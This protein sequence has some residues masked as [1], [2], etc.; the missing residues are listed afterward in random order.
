MSLSVS[1]LSVGYDAHNVLK[2]LN[3]SPLEKGSF[4]ALLGANAAGK[5][6]LFKSIAGLI[7]TQSGEVFLDG[8]ELKTYSKIQRARD[9]IY[10]PQSFYSS[11]ALSV[12][13]SVLV[14]F[15]QNSGWRVK[16][17]DIKQVAQ[18][19]SLLNIEHLA[20]KNI[21][22]LSGGQK[23]L[24]ALARILVVNPKVILLDE[25][26]SALDLHHQ[27]SI[28][29]VIKKLTIERN[30]ITIAALHDVNLAA[31]FCD[32]IMLLN[33]GVIQT[34]GDALDVLA[35][36]ELGEAYKVKTTLEHGSKGQLYL[37]AELL[38]EEMQRAMA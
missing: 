14:S 11:L 28:L 2:S 17:D 29:T 25:P 33:K 35:M 38:R 22:E 13:E 15:K 3:I 34:Q 37:D 30:F 8:K 27:L 21:S 10:L 6:T 12:F 31:K 7:K 4:T 18:V 16:P 5:S 32:Q 26:T 9:V 1:N 20:K 24:V 23:Q 19:L 36:P